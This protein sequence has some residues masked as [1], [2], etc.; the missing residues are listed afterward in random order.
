MCVPAK[1]GGCQERCTVAPKSVTSQWGEAHDKLYMKYHQLRR[2]LRG[3]EGKNTEQND[4]KGEMPYVFPV[5]L[6]KHRYEDGKEIH[7]CSRSWRHSGKDDLPEV[8]CSRHME[9]P[10]VSHTAFLSCN[11]EHPHWRRETLPPPPHRGP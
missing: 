5:G 10:D 11:Q 9:N 8:T 3:A 4:E 7:S 1:C 2:I 6:V